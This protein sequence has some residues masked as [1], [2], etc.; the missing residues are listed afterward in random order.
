MF[1]IPDELNPL[2]LRNKKALF[3]IL[4]AAASRTLL[5]IA[6][7]QK[8]LG[9]QLGFT[10][11]LHTWG[12][13]LLFHPHVHCVVTG[14]GL[15]TDAT[16]WIAAREKY[17][18]PVKVLATQPFTGVVERLIWAWDWEVMTSPKNPEQLA[19]AI[20][21]LVASYIDEV[22]RVA[23]Q[24]IDRTLSV[25]KASSSASKGRASQPAQQHQPAR[26][27]GVEELDGLCDRLY[28]LVCARPGV[29]MAVLADE[30]GQQAGRL[31]RPM[32]RLKADSRVRS[33][34]QR[35][36]MRYFP[37]VVRAP[38]SAG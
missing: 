32:T 24:A 20:E 34:G 25:S 17:L 8:H 10:M 5:S 28:E 23:Q 33:V 15:S 16:R 19:E 26:R 13:N 31:R 22:R 30:I 9:A 11:V 27:R 36:A 38:Q 37:A 2:A 3:D 12:Q 21:A 6:R 14:G 29:S 7:D 35:Q 1:T 4:F 18:L